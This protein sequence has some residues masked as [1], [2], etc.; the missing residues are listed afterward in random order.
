MKLRNLSENQEHTANSL[1]G[2]KIKTKIMSEKWIACLSVPYTALGFTDPFT[3]NQ[4]I[5]FNIGSLY[6]V[7]PRKFETLAPWGNPNDPGTFAVLNTFDNGALSVKEERSLLKTP[8]QKGTTAGTVA[9]HPNGRFVFAS[10]RGINEI[11]CFELT[12]TG[13]LKFIEKL[14]SGGEHPRFLAVHHEGTFLLCANRNSNSITTFKIDLQSG[15]LANTGRN[16][17]VPAPTAILFTE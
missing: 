13:N 6:S 2:I 16:F 12:E 3:E 15:K 17:K 4:S 11:H 9:V 1:T 8:L 10:I 7:A 14:P 5:L